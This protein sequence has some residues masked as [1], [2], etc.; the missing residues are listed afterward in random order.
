MPNVTIFGS[1][2]EKS[3][4]NYYKA[5]ET[6][7]RILSGDGFDITTGGYGGIMEAALKGTENPN[8]K[9]TG[10]VL[11][12]PKLGNCN[13]YVN[14]VVKTNSYIDRLMKLIDIGDAFVVF[15]GGTGTHLEIAALLALMQRDIINK[16]PVVC[17]GSQWNEV[18]QTF[19]FYSE[20]AIDIINSVKHCDDPFEAAN[21]IIS[22]LRINN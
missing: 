20:S 2:N 13:A 11:N 18:L 10:I 12:D 22:Q 7:G 9:K 1:G 8:A 3:N 16:K 17:F 5:A 21:Y 14:N 4:S 6:L 15:P 19:A